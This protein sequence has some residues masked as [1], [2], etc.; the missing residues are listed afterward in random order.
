MG[1]VSIPSKTCVCVGSDG[2]EALF[3]HER[4]H[5]HTQVCPAAGVCTGTETE[6][7]YSTSGLTVS[8]GKAHC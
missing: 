7:L 4:I 1:Q 5:H 2:C 3:E 6:E 8:V